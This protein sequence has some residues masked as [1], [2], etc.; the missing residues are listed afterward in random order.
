MLQVCVCVRVKMTDRTINFVKGVIKSFASRFPSNV[1]RN[2]NWDRKHVVTAAADDSY[3]TV[4]VSHVIGLFVCFSLFCSSCVLFLPDFT[5]FI[6]IS[7]VC[8]CVVS[9]N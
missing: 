1:A 3:L 4:R 9:V 5:V 8:V 6:K 2:E 7:A